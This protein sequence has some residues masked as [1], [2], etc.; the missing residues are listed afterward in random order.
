MFK[1][2]IITNRGNENPLN[3]D[4]IYFN[5]SVINEVSYEKYGFSLKN[6]I[7]ACVFDGVGSNDYAI[8]ASSRAAKELKEYNLSLIND[9]NTLI[10]LVDI[11]NSSV[12]QEQLKYDSNMMSTF[13]GVFINKG[14]IYAGNIGD[15]KIYVY[16]N[17]LTSLYAAD[18]YDKYKQKNNIKDFSN[19]EHVITNC[20][21]IEDFNKYKTHYF[22]YQIMHKKTKVILMSDGV[23][24]YIDDIELNKIMKLDIKQ[25]METIKNI[26]IE[27]GAEDNYTFVIVEI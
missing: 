1:Y 26:V 2:G 21:G 4:S 17:K 8:C 23:S 16:D 7:H 9:R 5:K 24:D 14:V 18:T 3:E 6:N 19:S 15:S 11:L 27:N 12:V 13:A 22:R 25:I 20:L 10:N